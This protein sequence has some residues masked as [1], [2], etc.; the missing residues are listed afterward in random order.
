MRA[1]LAEAENMI[2][3][4]VSASRKIGYL[5]SPGHALPAA[6]SLRAHQ[7]DAAGAADRPDPVVPIIWGMLYHLSRCGENVEAVADCVDDSGP[8]REDQDP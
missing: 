5:D 4:A 2:R 6:G 8:N 7:L 3:T 1:N